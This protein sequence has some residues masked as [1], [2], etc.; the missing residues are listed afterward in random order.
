NLALGRPVSASSTQFGLPA[1]RAVDGDPGSRW[2]SGWS[3]NQSITVDLGTAQTLG[4][5]IL[6][7]EAAYGSAYRIEVGDGATWRPVFS[8]DTGDGDVDVVGFAPT[9]A[10]FVRLVGV[11]RG[12]G[13]GYSLW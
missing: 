4:R 8:T 7:W 11:R 1:G 5:V 10:R 13:F 2:S 12:T 6:R 9:T 3:D